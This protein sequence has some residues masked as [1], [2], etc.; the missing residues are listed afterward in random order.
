MGDG[1]GQSGP[2][3]LF[4]AHGPGKIGGPGTL[5]THGDRE[6][7]PQDEQEGQH[8]QHDDER[9]ALPP[10]IVKPWSVKIFQS[11]HGVYL[12]HTSCRAPGRL[13]S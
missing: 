9:H 11:G 2:G 4:A 8:T 7:Y 6:R 3:K 5:G 13:A 10:G 1:F 12:S